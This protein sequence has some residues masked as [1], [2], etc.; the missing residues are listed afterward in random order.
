MSNGRYFNLRQLPTKISPDLCNFLSM[1]AAA[2]MHLLTQWISNDQSNLNL[3]FN[4]KNIS[5]KV[6]PLFFSVSE[7]DFLA[8]IFRAGIINV[9]EKSDQV[10]VLLILTCT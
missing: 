7:C 6:F 2:I 10:A 5:V 4:F 3:I 1:S 9:P 8:D